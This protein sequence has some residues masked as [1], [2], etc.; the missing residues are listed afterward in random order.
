M[1]PSFRKKGLFLFLIAVMFVAGMGN[2]T[3]ATN[4]P[5]V[6]TTAFRKVNYDGRPVGAKFV[7]V[8]KEGKGGRLG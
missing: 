2:A 3:A 4:D 8:G 7:A 1:K 6:V 5:Q